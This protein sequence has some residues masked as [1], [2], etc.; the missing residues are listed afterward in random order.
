M[1]CE[2]FFAWCKPGY[3]GPNCAPMFTLLTAVIWIAPATAAQRECIPWA[4]S[5]RDVICEAKGGMGK[6]TSY[7]LAVLQQL[8]LDPAL[9]PAAC[10]PWC[11]SPHASSRGRSHANLSVTPSTCR[12]CAA[13]PW[14]LCVCPCCATPCSGLAA[15]LA[16][17]SLRVSIDDE[18]CP[19]DDP[20]LSF[21]N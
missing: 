16:F 13:A 10:S 9:D 20:H 15:R 4:I 2:A 8:D 1:T 12:A 3:R 5:G 17:A 7:I 6:T 18:V 14:P 21:Q 11:S 19:A